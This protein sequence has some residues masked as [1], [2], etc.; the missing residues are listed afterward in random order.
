[1]RAPEA[2]RRA[3]VAAGGGLAAVTLGLLSALLGPWTGPAWFA[4]LLGAYAVGRWSRRR[5]P[6]RRPA[7][8]PPPRPARGL[9]SHRWI[10]AQLQG[11]RDRNGG[12]Y[13]RA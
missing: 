1:M 13:P 11:A 4:T 6:R 8:P 12:E 2:L 5:P 10:V 3:L 7:D 9:P